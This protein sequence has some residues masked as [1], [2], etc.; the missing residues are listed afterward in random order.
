MFATGLDMPSGLA[1]S[2]DGERLF[3]GEH[4]S[5]KIHV[6]EVSSGALLKTI[7]TGLKSIGGLDFSPS[8]NT[9][10]FVDSDRNS[11]YAV[12][13]DIECTH[14]YES[15]TSPAFLEAIEEAKQDSSVGPEDFSLVRDYQCSVDPVIPDTAFFE[16]VH[17]DTGYASNDT[18]VQNEAGMDESA[19]LLANRTDCEYDS[20]LNF[21]VLLLG[22]YFC[23][24]CLPD[25]MRAE[26]DSGGTCTNVQWDGYICDN[27][28]VVVIDEETNSMILQRSDGEEVDTSSI[29]LNHGITYRFTVESD[30]EVAFYKD[31]TFDEPSALADNECGCASMGPLIV[32]PEPPIDSFYLRSSSG[33]FV[34]LYM[35]QE[36]PHGMRGTR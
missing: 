15:R 20:D 1:L 22:G 13:Q 2:P 32:T 16:Q 25:G 33:A 34:K 6:F 35:K 31:D 8:T 19:A 23:H 4:R 9:L 21:D 26:C 17:A 10:H 18:D 30:I 36:S 7:E 27:E 28:F 5:G 24:E 29:L 3:V 12:M 11:L 14:A